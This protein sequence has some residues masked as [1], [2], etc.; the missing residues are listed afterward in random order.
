M[1]LMNL[2]AVT[3]I[4]ESKHLNIVTYKFTC[5]TRAS[6]TIKH[7][8]VLEEEK[9]AE[10]AKIVMTTLGK[11]THSL[12]PKHLYPV[13]RH[14]SRRLE[15]SWDAVDGQQCPLCL[16]VP[17]TRSTSHCWVRLSAC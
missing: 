15:M 17:S 3:R 11:T 1:H 4:H 9:R 8:Q 16:T 6:M 5:S 13:A 7:T 2:C 10:E 12:V 14:M